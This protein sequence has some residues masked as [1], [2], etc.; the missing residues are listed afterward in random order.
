MESCSVCMIPPSRQ[1]GD[2]C[3]TALRCLHSLL[4]Q[5]T[6]CPAIACCQ[7][8]A[9]QVNVAGCQQAKVTA[10][11]LLG[12]ASSNACLAESTAEEQ[13]HGW[14]GPPGRCSWVTSLACLVLPVRLAPAN[15]VLSS[16]LC[17]CKAAVTGCQLPHAASSTHCACTTPSLPLPCGNR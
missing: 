13:Q 4:L 8:W 12:A 1:P 2:K 5:I 10:L 17:W 11:T 9:W 14:K 7:G 16:S 6:S 3:S 15:H